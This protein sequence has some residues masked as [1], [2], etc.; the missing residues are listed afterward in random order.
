MAKLLR[1]YEYLHCTRKTLGTIVFMGFL[2]GH[3]TNG[4]TQVADLLSIF[5]RLNNIFLLSSTVMATIFSETYNNV[6]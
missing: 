1:N 2:P 3:I 5:F 6:L 4:T